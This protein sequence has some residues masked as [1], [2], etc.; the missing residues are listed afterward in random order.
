M[1][2]STMT[3]PDRTSERLTRVEENS[4]SLKKSFAVMTESLKTYENYNKRI[5][6]IETD[7]KAL[8]HT[9]EQSKMIIDMIKWGVMLLIPALLSV[10][11]ALA[12]ELLF[13]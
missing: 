9:V 13:K 2:C 5:T 8:Q 12:W 6:A 11:G 3:P 4:S 1:A 7:M 10:F